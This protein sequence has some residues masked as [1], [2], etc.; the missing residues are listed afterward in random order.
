MHWREAR[1]SDFVRLIKAVGRVIEV[2]S[3][4]LEVGARVDL[5]WYV[6]RCGIARVCLH[7]HRN[8][9]VW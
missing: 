7:G 9:I 3:E 8:R 5:A 4:V 1:R 6:I 2:T